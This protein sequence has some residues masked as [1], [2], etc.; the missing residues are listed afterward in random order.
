MK[1]FLNILAVVMFVMA[2]LA[3]PSLADSTITV[4]PVTP[5]LR[6]GTNRV[7]STD[8]TQNVVLANFNVSSTGG[9]S[10]TTKVFALV[11]Q[12]SAKPS[13]F[14]VYE[15]TTLV[16]TSSWNDTLNPQQINLPATI[17][18]GTTRTFTL[19]GNFP[20]TTSGRIRV[21]IMAVHFVSSNG[22]QYDVAPA[23]ELYGPFQRFFSSVTNWNLVSQPTIETISLPDGTPLALKSVFTMQATANG[24]NMLQPTKDDFVVVAQTGPFD[25]IECDNINVTTFPNTDIADGTT[26]TVTVTAVM[27]ADQFLKPGL[28][29]MAIKQIN[30]GP[31]PV[32]QI[33][34]NWGLEDYK[35]PSTYFAKLAPLISYNLPQIGAN[36]YAGITNVNGEIGTPAQI[37]GEGAAIV[38]NRFEVSTTRRV[39]FP[40]HNGERGHQMQVVAS[41][42]NNDMTP[43]IFGPANP[44]T[45]DLSPN[46]QYPVSNVQKVPDGSNPSVIKTVTFDVT[47]GDFTAHGIM[48]RTGRTS[49]RIKFFWG[50][51]S[52]YTSPGSTIDLLNIS[53]GT[54]I[55]AKGYPAGPERC[56]FKEESPHANGTFSEYL[57]ALPNSFNMQGSSDL[58]NWVNMGWAYSPLAGEPNEDGSVRAEVKVY[59]YQMT[60]AGLD[61]SRC[62]FRFVRNQ[63]NY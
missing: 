10:T 13:A 24:S 61:P 15:G 20:T 2:S 56:M 25:A 16:A 7:S 4:S 11:N 31:S 32:G 49:C 21:Q 55:L 27:T 57:T 29:N 30:W 12:I 5:P 1:K 48:K 62:F 35:T 8:T 50:Q 14:S 60:D 51:G 52:T 38:L 19:K 33:E 63:F 53:P 45:D 9:N 41:I 59:R 42:S 26:V 46:F 17:T 36:L 58:V 39:V 44:E 37:V 28:Y 34:Q 40:Y 47:I 18:S 54:E 6:D 3:L 22:I 43:I 23:T